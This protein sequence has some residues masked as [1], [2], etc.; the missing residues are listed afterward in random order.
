MN[1]TIEGLLNTYEDGKISRRD[2]IASLSALSLAPTLAHAQES[3]IRATTLNHV[4]LY[5][6]DVERS[7]RFYQES[8]GL[9]LLSRQE[10]GVN[11]AVGDSFVGIY[12]AG[13]RDIE[14]NHFCL[15]VDGFEQTEVLE[16]LASRG[17]EGEVRM[18]EETVPEIYFEDPDGLRVQLQD[19]SYC[20]GS[21]LLGNVC[22]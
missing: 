19:V 18:R 13:E 20:G 15:G 21:G 6:S 11:L 17:V 4:T 12:A 5:V 10:T 14:I 7:T 2:L 9:S 1:R 16:S 8:L 3:S 22:P